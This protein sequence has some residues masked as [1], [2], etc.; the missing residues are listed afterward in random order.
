MAGRKERR[1][2]LPRRPMSDST[3]HSAHRHPLTVAAVVGSFSVAIGLV[4]RVSGVLTGAEEGLLARYQEA[5]FSL[6]ATGQPWW[7]IVVL[8]LL[9]YG[10]AW[11]LLEVPGLSRRVMLAFTALILVAAASPVA[12]LWG[13]F[14]S[15]MLAVVCGG[16]SAFCASLWAWHHPMPCEQVEV[17]GEGKVISLA[18]EQERKTG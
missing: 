2:L 9:T 13:V 10:L 15:P 12:A 11:L 3:P 4:I 17:L 18:E 5:G 6:Q 16:W 8:M 1:A 7:G 14:W